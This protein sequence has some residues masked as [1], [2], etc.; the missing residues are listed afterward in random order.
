M[1]YNLPS[2]HP[3]CYVFVWMFVMDAMDVYLCCVCTLSLRNFG[4]TERPSLEFLP[5]AQ[6]PPITGS[7]GAVRAQMLASLWQCIRAR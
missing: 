2:Q 7:R 1:A 5:W 6:G 4:S 3:L